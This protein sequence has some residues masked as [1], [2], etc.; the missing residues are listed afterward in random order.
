[1]TEKSLK[2]L[3]KLLR[4]ETITGNTEKAERCL[5]FIK[6]KLDCET[7]DIEEFEQDD[8]SILVSFKEDSNPELILHGHIDVVEPSESQQF[9]PKKRDGKIFARGAADMKAGV[10]CIISCFRRLKQKESRPSVGLMITSDEERGG[11]NGAGHIVNEKSLQPKLVIS[12]E[13]AL[14][15]FPEIVYEH[16]GVL[17]LKI[18]AL[19]TSCHASYPERGEN[20]ADRLLD[21]YSKIKKLFSERGDFPTTVTLTSLEAGEAVNKAPSEASMKLD[22]RHSDEYFVDEVLSDIEQIVDELEVIARAPMMKNNPQNQYIQD[23]TK[24]SEHQVNLERANYASDMRFFT[25][26]NITAIIF[27]PKGGNVHSNE[28][29]VSVKSMEDYQK[30]LEDFIEK[31]I[32]NLDQSAIKVDD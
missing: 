30:I 6:Q 24:C 3:E 31:Y 10:S 17:Q 12:S 20:A 28:E 14:H 22:I 13:P 23:L 2:L 27:G 29:Y 5:K 7:V 16:K 18:K 9:K 21:Q 4:F 15:S 26:K 32:K 25:Q 8:P 19:G 1:M 11:F